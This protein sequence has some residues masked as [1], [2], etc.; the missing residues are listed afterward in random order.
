MYVEKKKIGKQ[1]YYYAK[2]S[3]RV[4]K[5]VKAKTIAYL[6]KG[7][8]KKKEL[9]DKMRTISPSIEVHAK[10]KVIQKISDNKN[11]FFLIEDQIGKLK[12]IQK[13]FQKKRLLLGNKLEKEMFQDFKTHYIY[14]TNAI[15]GNTLTFEETHF[16]LNEHKS[17]DGKDLK[18][19]YDH[20]N[21]KETFDWLFQE[22]H[23]LTVEIILK[24]HAQLLKNID[25]RV[26]AFRRYNVRV[27][28]ATF[29]PTDA[30]YIYTDMKLLF[31]WYNE[32]THL[33]H[34]LL[35][36]A[37]FHEKFERIHPF[38]DGNGRTGRMLV[39]L[40]LLRAH[41][42]PFIIKNKDRKIY[43]HVLSEGHH[44]SLTETTSPHYKAIAQFF[45]DTFI[46]TYQEIFSKW[47]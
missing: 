2:T 47:G 1:S 43:Y 9:E 27:L 30:Q 37:L 17:P 14:N 33:L 16:L 5:T 18:E 12:E 19:I 20:I 21:E 10:K 39:N 42:P 24:I 11:S 23:S 3:V 44:T 38:Y 22:K 28:G 36:A 6:G 34:P 29:T 32:H 7:T 8:M 35:L 45:Y 4:G 40:I 41:L 26:N 25:V 31:Q 13:D 46:E 15:E